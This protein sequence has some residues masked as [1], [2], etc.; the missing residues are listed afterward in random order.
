MAA[1]ALNHTL[2]F[3][4]ILL[5]SV[6]IVAATGLAALAFGPGR[7]AGGATNDG[8]PPAMS[9]STTEASGAS[10]QQLPPDVR[11]SL[12]ALCNGCTF[13]DAG[14]AWNGGDVILDPSLPQRQ[15]RDVSESD[16]EWHIRYVRGGYSS[17]EFIVVF[18]KDGDGT[19]GE[20]SRCSGS[21]DEPCDW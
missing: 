9:P 7:P 12:Q 4:R 16:D 18:A 8:S 1:G 19:P 5:Q 14:A 21:L 11:A 6:L 15:L 2:G 10:M 13:A 20:G 3:R 17:R